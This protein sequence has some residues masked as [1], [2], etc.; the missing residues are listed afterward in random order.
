MRIDDNIVYVTD[1]RREDE[2]L[3]VCKAENE[4]G[5]REVTA[6]LAVTGIGESS[7]RNWKTGKLIF[8]SFQVI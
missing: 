3:Y 5:S 6:Q 7:V 1:V 2:G 4:L 8:L